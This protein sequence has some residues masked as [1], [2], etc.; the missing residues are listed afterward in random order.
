MTPS[1]KIKFTQLQHILQTNTKNYL[2]SSKKNNK[3]VF[4]KLQVKSISNI[5]TRNLSLPDF[6]QL[7]TINDSSFYYINT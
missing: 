7:V 4:N 2:F 5:S 1:I 3:L 6:T